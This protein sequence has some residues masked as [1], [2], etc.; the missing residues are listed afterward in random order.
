MRSDIDHSVEFSDFTESG[1]RDL[2][3]LAASR[4]RFARF[5]DSSADRHVLWRHDID[6]SVNRAVRLAEIEAELGIISTYFLHFRSPFYNLMNSEMQRLIRRIITLG[7]D[8]GLHFD[9]SR[10]R[11][12]LSRSMLEAAITA[13]SELLSRE[14]G[15]P[16]CAVSFHDIG[17]LRE[18]VPDDDRLCGLVNAYSKHLRDDYGYIS[19]SNGIW[20]YRRL[21]DVLNRAEEERLQVLTHP[22]WWTPEVMA[23][24]QRIQRAIDGHATN[25]AARYDESLSLLNRPNVR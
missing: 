20:R 19:D 25:L 24:R 7:H 3:S 8:L 13:E 22:E 5:G 2:L 12:D 21:R 15:T 9:L 16:P 11:Q 10:H 6:I 18:P 4:Y 1:Y 14:F 17:T 23:P